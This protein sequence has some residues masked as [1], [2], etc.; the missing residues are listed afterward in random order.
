MRDL[1]EDGDAADRPV[2]KRCEVEVLSEK[3]RSCRAGKNNNTT[4]DDE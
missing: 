2:I 1:S 3:K 4:T